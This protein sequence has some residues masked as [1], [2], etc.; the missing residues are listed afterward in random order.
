[1][2]DDLPELCISDI[3]Q[4]NLLSRV[5][6]TVSNLISIIKASVERQGVDENRPCFPYEKVK[7]LF[8]DMQTKISQVSSL[9]SCS[10]PFL[11]RLCVQ[12]VDSLKVI[13]LKKIEHDQTILEE[14][15]LDRFQFVQD[16]KLLV[17]EYDD[18]SLT[19]KASNLPDFSTFD[20]L[21]L[22]EQFI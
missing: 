13:F 17:S 18:A 6:S 7:A 2:G 20:L 12:L 5:P 1:V 16:L 22:G 21:L 14:Q 3:L 15:S 10:R 19:T 4:D 11:A 9:S 8:E